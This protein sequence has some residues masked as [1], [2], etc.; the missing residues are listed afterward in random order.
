M[1][2]SYVG[3]VMVIYNYTIESGSNF[4]EPDETNYSPM[5]PLLA[6]AYT[7]RVIYN[8]LYSSVCI[9]DYFFDSMYRSIYA[10]RKALGLRM[11]M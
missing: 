11:V 3:R 2:H 1:K 8:Q 7:H 5:I 4:P 9:P 6:A 10:L